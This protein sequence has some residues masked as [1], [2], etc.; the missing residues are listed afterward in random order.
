[1]KN[2]SEND[3]RDEIC[4]YYGS[5]EARYPVFFKILTCQKD[6]DAFP[7]FFIK[8]KQYKL[9]IY[10]NP[11]HPEDTTNVA[12]PGVRGF[13]EIPRE[14]FGD[15]TKAPNAITYA[16]Y[17]EEVIPQDYSGF[18]RDFCKDKTECRIVRDFNRGL[19]VIPAERLSRKYILSLMR[20]MYGHTYLYTV[21]SRIYGIPGQKMIFWEVT[22][23]GY[24]RNKPEC[25]RSYYDIIRGEFLKS[26]FPVPVTDRIPVAPHSINV[27]VDGVNFK[28][29]GEK[30][31]WSC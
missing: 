6:Y 31:S 8:G 15:F 22:M 26:P 23:S 12:I 13:K 28:N 18:I 1:M 21:V 25:I 19:Y 30:L 11:R 3:V 17:K 27:M 29:D 10:H 9:W 7:Y 4:R 14:V 16:L 24:N 20:K 2:F 5:V